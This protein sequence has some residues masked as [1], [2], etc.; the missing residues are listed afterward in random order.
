MRRD[1]F[2]AVIVALLLLVTLGQLGFFNLERLSRGLENL[3]VFSRETVPPDLNVAALGAQ[4]LL[5]TIQMAFAGTLL[6]FIMALPLGALG[7]ATLF[8]MTV[9]APIRLLVAA[10]R[11]VPS[12][13]WGVLFVIFIGLGPLAGTLALAFYTLGYMAKLFAE[14]F[15]GTD[16]EV[17]EAVRGLGASKAQLARFV[18]WPENANAVL[19]QVLFLMEYNVR[20]S[21]IL[22]FVG[23]GGIGFYMQV[24]VQTLEYQRLATLLL[25]ILGMVVFM[26]VLSAWIR[27]RYLVGA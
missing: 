10:I 13:V 21:A 4:A 25:L 18:L 9:V 8:P 16:T 1:L 20:A 5:E 19:S 15:E 17:I 23:A 14:F 22:G 6:G 2:L 24:Y 26:D 12:L 11:T 7:T 3:L 27:R